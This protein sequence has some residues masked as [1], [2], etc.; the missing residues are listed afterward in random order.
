M[1]IPYI[2][3]GRGG[4]G[5]GGEDREAGN[6]TRHAISRGTMAGNTSKRRDASKVMPCHVVDIWIA[7]GSN[8]SRG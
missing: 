6:H 2:E 7:R 3:R 8:R 1:S 5:R 4:E